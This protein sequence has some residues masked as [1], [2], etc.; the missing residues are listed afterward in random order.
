MSVIASWE[1]NEDRNPSYEIIFPSSFY[2]F[3]VYV[4]C[5]TLPGPAADGRNGGAYGGFP[6][7]SFGCSLYW[8]SQGIITV[9]TRG[10]ACIVVSRKF[11]SELMRSLVSHLSLFYL[12]Y[13]LC[14][15]LALLF[16]VPVLGLFTHFSQRKK[17]NVFV[18]LTVMDTQRKNTLSCQLL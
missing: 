7:P 1:W 12:F 8:F 9:I 11:S 13:F 2:F 3:I 17:G 18:L 15:F 6:S 10:K 14:V 16:S 5:L 4:P